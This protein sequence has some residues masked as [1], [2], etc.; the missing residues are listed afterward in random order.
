MS[1]NGIRGATARIKG[2][3]SKMQMEASI[4]ADGDDTWYSYRETAQSLGTAMLGSAL[5]W[6]YTSL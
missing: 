5:L 1:K 3:V 6:L 4:L 2:P